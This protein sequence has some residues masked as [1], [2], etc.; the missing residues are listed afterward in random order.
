MYYLTKAGVKFLNEVKSSV[1]HEAAIRAKKTKDEKEYQDWRASEGKPRT[2]MQDKDNPD[3]KMM[4]A[5]APENFPPYRV[6]KHSP[7]QYGQRAGIKAGDLRHQRLKKIASETWLN[8]I[9]RKVGK[10]IRKAE[11]A[12]R[13][14]HSGLTV[15]GPGTGR[16]N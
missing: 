4:K 8:R 15:V 2:P 10:A 7:E 6:D 14:P 3:T 5:L 16:G 12:I 1:E 13:I 11:I 9:P